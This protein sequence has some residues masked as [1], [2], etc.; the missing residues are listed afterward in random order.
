MAGGQRRKERPITALRRTADRGQPSAVVIVIT[1]LAIAALFN[2]LRIRI[3]N[4]IDRR[5][6]RRKYD[7]QQIMQEFSATA[8]SNVSLE[9]ISAALLAVTDET[10]QPGSSSLWLKKK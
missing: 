2:P 1:T 5:F 3:Q 6:Y 10:M 9:E 8:R 4:G 7:S